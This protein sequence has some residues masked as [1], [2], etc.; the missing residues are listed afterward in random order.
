MK[1]EESSEG[2]PDESYDNIE[3]AYNPTD[4]SRLSVSTEIK[5]LFQY[6]ERYKPHEVEIDSTLKCFIPDYLPAIGDI[7][8]FVKIP[9]PDGKLD[10]LGL[11]VL[12]EP[13]TQQSDPTMLELQLRAMSKKLQ[14]GDVAVR[15]IDNAAKNPNAI[16][17]WIQSVNDLHRTKPPPH[18]T[19]KKNMP[20]I[21]KLMEAWP[22]DFEQALKLIPLPSPDLDMSLLEYVKVV[23]AILDIPVYDNPIESLHILFSLFLDF[24]NNPHFQARLTEGDQNSFDQRAD[25]KS[26]YDDNFNNNG[27]VSDM[28]D[29]DYK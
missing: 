20:D 11:K 9:R 21:E 16:E 13:S 26:S 2:E 4:F 1:L 3:G 23:C 25:N 24:R 14:Y 6:I 27:S 22:E 10:D 19:Y 18:V 17:K 7:D 28:L 15:S 29:S 5:D 12:D 8:Y